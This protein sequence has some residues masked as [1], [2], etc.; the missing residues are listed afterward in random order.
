MKQ[1]NVSR[2]EV[3]NKPSEP[4]KIGL[5]RGTIVETSGPPIKC[6]GE[7]WMKIVTVNKPTVTGYVPRKYLSEI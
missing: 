2:L 4:S 1:I 7:E 3:R 6:K 5:D